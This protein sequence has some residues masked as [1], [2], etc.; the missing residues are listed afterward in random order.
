[1]T[2]RRWLGT[3]VLAATLAGSSVGSDAS[4]AASPE[5]TPTPAAPG[6]PCGSIASLVD[7]PTVTTSPCT[8]RP[9]SVLVESGYTNSVTS[10]SG[11][12]TTV[13]YP[14]S[15]ARVGS[16]NPHLEFDFEPPQENRSSAGGA[17]VTGAGDVGLGTKYE[18]GYTA[19]W[20]YGADVIVAFPSG[21]RAF[22]AGHVQPSGGFD[23]TYTASSAISL[24]GTVGF[25]G[26]A[27][28]PSAGVSTTLSTQS[29]F[30]AE[31]AYFTASGS[32]LIKRG[33]PNVG[34]IRDIGPHVQLDVEY[35][36]APLS[37][38]GAG[39]YVGAGAS[40]MY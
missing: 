7:R 4:L 36:F 37:S 22:S 25:D 9:G 15:F 21:T 35:G 12:G 23:W 6:D 24:F 16:W 1:M 33:L 14:E 28:V 18:I 17:L 11:G 38:A 3:G 26:T 20:T 5:P 27:F 39:H 32:N 8:V 40:F 34:Y 10:G 19:Q 13:T 31:Y 2:T 30:Y 29:S